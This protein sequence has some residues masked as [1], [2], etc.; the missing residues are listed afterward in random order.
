MDVF[1]FRQQLVSEYESFTRSFTRSRSA[2]YVGRVAGNA[3][4]PAA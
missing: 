4:V 2:G 3:Y 1:D